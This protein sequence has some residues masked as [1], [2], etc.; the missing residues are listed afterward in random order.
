MKVVEI[1]YSFSE[2]VTDALT[3]LFTSVN[4]QVTRDFDLDGINAFVS[5]TLSDVTSRKI[6]VSR[7]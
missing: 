4:A 3:P 7:T 6:D 1:T 5:M 2:G